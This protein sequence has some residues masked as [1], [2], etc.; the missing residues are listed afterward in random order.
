MQEMQVWSLDQVWFPGEGNGNPPQYS[1]PENPINRGGW[2]AAVYGV[3]KE[4]DMTYQL[5]KDNSISS[6]TCTTSSDGFFFFL[7]LMAFMYCDGEGGL[8]SVLAPSPAR[9]HS[10]CSLWK[11]W[12]QVRRS[13]TQKEKKAL[14]GIT[15]IPT[16]TR[17]DGQLLK[18]V[19]PLDFF[20]LVWGVN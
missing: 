3:S 7:L 10:W 9:Q 14:S 18:W 19:N 16:S 4:L 12:S 20:K 8:G 5:N 15:W 13:R 6:Y 1:C 2:R 11:E 17:C